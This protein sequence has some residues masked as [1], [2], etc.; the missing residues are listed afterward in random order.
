VKRAIEVL[1]I[2]LSNIPNVAKD[3]APEVEVL[4]FT[5]AGPVLCVRPFTHTD[6]YWQVYFAANELIRTELAKEGFSVPEQHFAI[7]TRSLS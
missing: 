3:V 7:A 6:H 4:S 1:K 2:A 5:L